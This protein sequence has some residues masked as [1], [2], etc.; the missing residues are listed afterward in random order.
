MA[1]CT[2]IISRDESSR[3]NVPV[4]ELEIEVFET[5]FGDLF[6]GLFSVR[7]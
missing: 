3:P 7:Y 1:G 4:A 2:A 5:G 6:D